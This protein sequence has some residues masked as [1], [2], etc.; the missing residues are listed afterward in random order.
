MCVGIGIE[1]QALHLCCS[2]DICLFRNAKKP[3]LF[4]LA[5]QR[6]TTACDQRLLILLLLLFAPSLCSNCFYHCHTPTIPTASTT[7]ISFTSFITVSEAIYKEH[8]SYK[9]ISGHGI[10]EGVPSWEE[11]VEAPAARAVGNGLVRLC[12]KLGQVSHNIEPV[13]R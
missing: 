5:F 10:L 1:R 7:S 9:V 13:C 11:H 6:H 2:L 8:Q 3:C 12:M 4:H